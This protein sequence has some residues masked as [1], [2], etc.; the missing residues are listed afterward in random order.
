MRQ[1]QIAEPLGSGKDGFVLVGKGQT[2]PARVAIK[3]H[4]FEEHY[5]REKA[6]YERLEEKRIYL[7]DVTPGNIGFPLREPG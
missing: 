6:V 2:A 4:Q 3:A 5:S 7:M 1:L